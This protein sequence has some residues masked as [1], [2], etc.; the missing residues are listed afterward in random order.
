[1]APAVQFPRK[2]ACPDEQTAFP[3]VHHYQPW[4]VCNEHQPCTYPHDQLSPSVLAYVSAGLSNTASKAHKGNLT[5]SDFVTSVAMIDLL[6]KHFEEVHFDEAFRH[7]AEMIDPGTV[8]LT[9]SSAIQSTYQAFHK[10]DNTFTLNEVRE[11]LRGS[12]SRSV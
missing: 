1:M 3:P 10:V 4:P 2:D 5:Q 6:R 7:A 8:D 12:R 11:A 9:N